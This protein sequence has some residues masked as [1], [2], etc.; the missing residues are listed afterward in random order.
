MEPVA[1]WSHALAAALYSAL[2]LWELRR[3]IRIGSEHRMLLAA[4]ALTACWAWLTAV[5]PSSLLA[6]YSETARNLA[7]VGVLYRLAVGDRA[8]TRQHGVQPVY[9][10]VAAALGL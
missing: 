10:A 3:G 6:A 5:D 8:E 7:W 4:L 9:A 1:F 2:T